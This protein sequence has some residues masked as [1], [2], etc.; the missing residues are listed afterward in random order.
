MTHMSICVEVGDWGDGQIDDIHKLL[1]DVSD[2]FLIYFDDLPKG[3]IRVQCRPNE[4]TPRIL[5]RNSPGDDFTIWLTAQ[6][7]Y[8][9][10]YSYQFA[11]ELCH[12]ASD[13]ERL[14]LTANQWFH[15][16]LCELASLFTLKKMAITW[17][18][19]PPYSHWSSYASALAS[20]AEE[21]VNR[22][23]H[24]LP[25]EVSLADWLHVNEATLRAD[26]YQ[27][28]LNGTVAVK[29][30]PFLLASPMYWQSIRYMPNT[31]ERFNI[32]LSAWHT[33]CPD[34]Q[35][36]FPSHVAEQFQIALV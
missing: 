14:R 36:A 8:W 13:F 19:N 21:I 33:S 4:A 26:P 31:D 25:D 16:A 20:Y 30:L 22:N 15:E 11:H 34:D 32:F 17:Q 12:F 27:R 10:K 3:N 1:V 18:S 35:K 2:Q 28:S 24:R 5:Y 6:D 9:A 29:L 23:E 7:R